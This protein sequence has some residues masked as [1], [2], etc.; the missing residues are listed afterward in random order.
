MVGLLEDTFYLSQDL[1]IH[2]QLG[3]DV[4]IICI[5]NRPGLREFCVQ[6][7]GLRE[8]YHKTP[9]MMYGE[10]QKKYLQGVPLLYPSLV[11]DEVNPSVPVKVP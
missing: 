3:L 2:V 7:P 5:C 8:F 6:V 1:K 9:E 10:V 11:L 4:T